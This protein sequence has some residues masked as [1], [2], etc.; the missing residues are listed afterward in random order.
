MNKSGFYAGFYGNLPKIT[1]KESKE[2]F[3][4]YKA[5]DLRARDE[6]LVKNLRLVFA[7]LKRYYKNRTNTDDLFE[8][9]AL[10][11]VKATKR[12]DPKVG[13]KFSTYAVP[14]I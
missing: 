10:G 7:V 6:F 1:E 12:F 14:I 2:L 13:V 9:G 11:L 4:R 8:A 3:D 5:G